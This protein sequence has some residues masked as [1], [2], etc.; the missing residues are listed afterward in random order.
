MEKVKE[1]GRMPGEREQASDS[2][3]VNRIASS[4]GGG[5]VLGL[6]ERLQRYRGRDH[7]G[8]GAGYLEE[9]R[10][11][12]LDGGQRRG[13]LVDQHHAAPEQRGQRVALPPPRTTLTPDTT[14]QDC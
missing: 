4:A 1:G 9:A 8:I 14:S 13:D 10:G 5:G 3:V 2:R 7:P 11:I 6:G 12:S